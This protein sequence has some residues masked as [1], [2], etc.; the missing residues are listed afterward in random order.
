M[1]EQ[2]YDIYKASGILVV[3]RMVLASRTRGK[4]I[5]IQPGGRL[6]PEESEIDAVIRELEEEFGI[7]VREEDLEKLGDYYADAAGQ[8]NKRV[9]VAAYLVRR[10]T[11]TPEPHSEVAEIRAFNS[12]IPEGVEVASILAHDI[13]PE[14]VARDL[15]D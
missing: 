2:P 4:N 13:I 7:G 8:A 12:Q 5:F 6:E 14:L 9:K 10:Y 15:I 11:G 1:T 3:D